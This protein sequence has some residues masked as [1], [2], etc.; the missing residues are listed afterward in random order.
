MIPDGQLVTVPVPDPA[1]V[2]V[3]VWFPIRVNAAVTFRACVMVTTQ[4]PVPLQAPLQPENVEFAS[5]CA[6]KVTC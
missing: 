4:D 2:T 6:L 5:A 3:R 1:F